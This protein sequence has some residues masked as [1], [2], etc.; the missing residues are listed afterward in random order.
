M[1]TPTSTDVN[2][3]IKLIEVPPGTFKEAGFISD[4]VEAN[5]PPA[6]MAAVAPVESTQTVA[7]GWY[8]NETHHNKSVDGTVKLEASIN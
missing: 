1:Q 3:V 6:G 8:L 7:P 2:A 5:V 4:V